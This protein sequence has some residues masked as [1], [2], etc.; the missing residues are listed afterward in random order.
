VKRDLQ[1]NKQLGAPLEK[2]ETYTL[3]ISNNWKSKS[4]AQ[5]SAEFTKSFIV[6]ARDSVSP[7]PSLWKLKIPDASTGDSLV[8]VLNESHDY[9][10]LK[11]AVFIESESGES[12]QCELFVKSK[13][14]RI[15]FVPKSEWRP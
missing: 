9:L 3:I 8:A 11:S 14:K 13:E 10:L 2:G 5:L 12:V 15:A 7:A 4:G 6:A 1:P